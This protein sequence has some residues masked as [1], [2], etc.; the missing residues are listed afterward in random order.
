M[1]ERLRRSWQVDQVV[2]ATTLHG[3]DDPIA[4]LAASLDV[5]CFRGSE[6]DVLDRVLKAAESASADL[7]VE[8]TG[9]CPLVDPGVV[10]AVINTFLTNR[11]DYCS[12]VLRPT[13]PRGMDVQVFPT[14]V[15][16]EVA[17]LTTDLADREHVSLY[18]YEHPERYRLLNLASGLP[19]HWHDLRLT[20]DTPED[21]ALVDEI[22]RALYPRRPDFSLGDILGLFA[23]RPE[24]RH[25]NAHVHQ[26]AVRSGEGS[27]A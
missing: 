4:S 22:Y 11:V 10:D 14:A 25:L 16:A 1:I 6:E 23:Q 26:K 21:F 12:N 9:D 13:Y 7:I 15:L 24:L 8:T 27:P 2:V 3:A 5:S 18:I 20:V 19:H 17:T